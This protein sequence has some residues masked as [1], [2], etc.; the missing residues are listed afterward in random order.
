MIIVYTTCAD[1]QEAD[2][3]ANHLLL[4]KLC[5]CTN[6]FPIKA[7]YVWKES[8][9]KEPEVALLIKTRKENFNKVQEEIKKVHS[10]ETPAIFSVAV[11]DVD[12]IYKQWLEK[13]T[14]QE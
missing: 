3:I 4:K 10:Y 6:S 1:Q 5:A 8:I 12:K 2:K 14:E 11:Q 13:E 9:M 7:M